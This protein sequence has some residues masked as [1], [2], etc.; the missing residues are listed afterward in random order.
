MEP[1]STTRARVR[2]R[3]IAEPGLSKAAAVLAFLIVDGPLDRLSCLAPAGFCRIAE[4]RRRAEPGL[5]L[6]SPSLR[7]GTDGIDRTAP[8]Q[9]WYLRLAIDSN[10]RRT[11]L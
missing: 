6:P 11:I 10:E 9:K 7:L 3:R 5:H 8:H 2:I 4:R 1:R